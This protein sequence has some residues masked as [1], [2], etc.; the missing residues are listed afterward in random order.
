MTANR[1]LTEAHASPRSTLAR[2]QAGLAAVAGHLTAGQRQSGYHVRV[3]K[4]ELHDPDFP[5]PMLM[6][7]F[8]ERT[9]MM[10][11]PVVKLQ[12]EAR[13]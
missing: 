1:G 8:A 6:T 9:S 2:W 13:A 10:R 7:G 12:G 5:D 4:A 11:S 3:R